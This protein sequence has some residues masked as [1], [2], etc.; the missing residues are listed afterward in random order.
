[1][2]IE[3]LLSDRVRSSLVNDGQC[4]RLVAAKSCEV[5]SIPSG[6]RSRR[7]FT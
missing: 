2:V 6:C 1:M 3:Y 7:F 5:E 4:C